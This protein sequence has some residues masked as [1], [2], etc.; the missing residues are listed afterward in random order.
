LASEFDVVVVGGGI[1][2]MTAGLTS[3]RLGRS[4]L[5]LT[6][7]MPGGQLLSIE[8]IDGFPG[9]PDGVPGYELCP[10]TQEQAA[11][12]GA[13][14]MMTSLEGV[15]ARQGKWSVATAED[16][17]MARALIVATGSALKMLDVPGEQRLVGKGAS[18][19]ASCDG[20]LF[21]DRIVAVIGG[22]D[23]AMQEALTLAQFAAKVIILHRAD[24]LGGQ[25]YYRDRV[26]ADPKIE[27]RCNTTV[28]EILGDTAVTALRTQDGRSG[29]RADL[30]V[31]AVFAYVGLRPNSGI[32]DGLMRLD[33]AG[34][35]PTDELMRTAL[36]GVCA[37]G[38]VRCNSPCRAVSAAGDGAS[39]AAAVDRYL[40]D[41]SWSSVGAANEYAR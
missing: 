37:A 1:A 2:G 21:R 3:A 27:L 25:A 22:G 11:A 5:V 9:F 4:T 26:T 38:T 23:S 20:P 18:Q 28:T 13:E 40:T 33:S 7:G 36:I 14:F 30:A 17:V 31:A 24:A 6:G 15:D 12:T 34:R 16:D 8:R 32:L 41:G 10:A 35:I 19:C 29:A 39:A